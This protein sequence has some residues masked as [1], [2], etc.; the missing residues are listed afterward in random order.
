MSETIITYKD[1]ENNVMA[2]LIKAEHTGQGIEF[3]TK[4]KDYMQV[5]DEMDK[6]IEE[7]ALKLGLNK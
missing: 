5:V 1:N 3:L 2:L 4:D 6:V 7:K